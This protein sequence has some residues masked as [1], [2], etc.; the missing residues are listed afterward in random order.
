MP[1]RAAGL[2]SQDSFPEVT[3]MD[4]CA[5]FT[6]QS[7]CIDIYLPGEELSQSGFLEKL[8]YNKVE[9]SLRCTVHVF[10]HILI[11]VANATVKIQNSSITQNIPP[12]VYFV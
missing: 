8:T 3:D 5:V 7:A 12:R 6:R 2:L 10:Q 4:F 1:S 9:C 11:H